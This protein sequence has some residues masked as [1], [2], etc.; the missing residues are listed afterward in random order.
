[1]RRLRQHNGDELFTVVDYR[2]RY[3]LYKMDRDLM[4]AH[5]SAPWVVTW[6]DHEVADNYAGDIDKYNTPPE[7]FVLRRAAA[8]QAYYETMPLRATALP[9]GSHMRL[10]RRLRFRNL[11]HLSMLA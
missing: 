2:N 8:Y 9:S 1:D 7:L 10:Y 11:I 3:A 6:D 4:A 5:A